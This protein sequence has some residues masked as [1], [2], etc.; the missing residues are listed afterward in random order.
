MRIL[1]HRPRQAIAT[2]LA[3]AALLAA[4][5]PSGAK[6]AGGQNRA[7]TPA[8]IAPDAIHLQMA[9]FAG[10]PAFN[11]PGDLGGRPLVLNVWAS[12]CGPCRQ[13]MPAFQQV[14]LQAKDRVSFLG[15]DSRDVVDAARRFAAQTGVTYRLA[16]DPDGQAAAKLGVAALPTTV[17][18]GADGTL[19]GRHV[20][21][22]TSTDLR[23]NI[24]RYLGVS[25]P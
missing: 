7:A 17:F 22:L 11:L 24:R 9:G 4:C 15:L 20:G 5:A 12:W 23:A 10:G 14:Y 3:G 8:G 21:A 2:L 13:E 19:R 16:A 18:I 1:D 25:V 6:Q